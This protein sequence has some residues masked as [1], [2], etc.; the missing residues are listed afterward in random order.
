MQSA[1]GRGGLAVRRWQLTYQE[2]QKGLVVSMTHTVPNPWTVMVHPAT[3]GA[4]TSS[5]DARQGSC[6]R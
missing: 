4:L 2:Q 5:A 1:R 6:A 3:A